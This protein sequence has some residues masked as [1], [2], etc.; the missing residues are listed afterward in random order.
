[1]SKLVPLEAR[2]K[3][4][5]FV[6]TIGEAARKAGIQASAIRYYERLG[7]LPAPA[8]VGGRRSY[9]ESILDFL[10]LVRFARHVGFNMREVKA[11]FGQD[12][13]GRRISKRWVALA[14]RKMRDSDEQVGRLHMARELLRRVMACRCVEPAQCGREI[15]RLARS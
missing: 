2:F 13:D 11:L 8:R 4:R 12:V 7:L 1:M 5:G 9:D 10:A 3:S 14:E 6:M 15:R